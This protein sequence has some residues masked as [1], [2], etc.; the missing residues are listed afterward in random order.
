MPHIIVEFSNNIKS[1]CSV[2]DLIGCVH[3][4]AIDSGVF[5]P[6]AV[7]T[8]AVARNVY[9]VGNSQD[10]S[11]GFILVKARIRPGRSDEAKNGLLSGLIAA[12]RNYLNDVKYSKP[13]MVNVEIHE[14]PPLREGFR[15]P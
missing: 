3:L 1:A 10:E 8:R 14:L 7:R 9:Q 11:A 15:L 5:E 4:A 2:D 6:A 13:L 12:V